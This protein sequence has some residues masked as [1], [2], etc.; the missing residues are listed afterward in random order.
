VSDSQTAR[1]PDSQ[2]VSQ[3]VSKPKV[4]SQTVR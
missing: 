4:D 1:Q 2:P 3:T